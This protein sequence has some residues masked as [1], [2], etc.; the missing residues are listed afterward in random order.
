MNKKIKKPRGTCVLKNMPSDHQDALYEYMDGIGDVQGH[1][2]KQCVE[3]MMQTYQIKTGH[4]QLSNWRKWYIQRMSFNWVNETVQV[5]IEA[6]MLGK[7][8]TQEDIQRVGNHMFSVLAIRT[9]DDK[10]WSRAQTNVV[11]RQRIATMERRLEF[12]IKKYEDQCA[13]QREKEKEAEPQMTV[14]EKNAR[15]RQIMGVD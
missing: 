2:Y 6:G 11:R 8:H 15:I 4:T 5:M 3:W 14:E 7:N 9:C 1:T 10:A 13:R 12:E